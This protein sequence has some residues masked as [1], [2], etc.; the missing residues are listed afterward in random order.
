MH[1]TA[2]FPFLSAKAKSLQASYDKGSNLEQVKD[3]KEFVSNELRTLKQQ[4]KLLELHIC[5]CE[6]ELHL[7]KFY[8]KNINLTRPIQDERQAQYYMSSNIEFVGRGHE[9]KNNVKVSQLRSVIKF[10]QMHIQV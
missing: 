1:M 6:V 4:H 10:L 8:S 9:S 5:A 2:V 7:T 3:M